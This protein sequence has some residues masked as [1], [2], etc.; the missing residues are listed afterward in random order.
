[1]LKEGDTT[2]LCTADGSGLMVSLIQSVSSAFGSGMIAEGTGVILNNRVGRGF[3]LVPGHPSHHAR[4]E[5]PMSTLNCWSVMDAGGEALMVG[6]SYGGD[7]G[8]ETRGLQMLVG[9]IDGGL[10]VQ[11]ATEIPR[12]EL[13]PRTDP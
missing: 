6:G 3:S 2:Y 10:D 7:G 4:L 12:W 5:K 9:M 1:M 11:A 8:G 13:L